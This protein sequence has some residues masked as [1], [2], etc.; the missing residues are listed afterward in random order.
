MTDFDVIVP[1]KEI[2][3]ER[4]EECRQIMIKGN[5]AYRKWMPTI[6]RRRS[7]FCRDLIVKGKLDQVLPFI[8]ADRH[9]EFLSDIPA[10]MCVES[11]IA[12]LLGHHVKMVVN[13]ASKWAKNNNG[14]KSTKR[15]YYD[16]G[17]LASEGFIA[18]FD[19]IR[20]YN[21]NDIVFMTYAWMTVSRRMFAS[22][23][24]TSPMS[25]FTR[26]ERQ[27]L[28]KIAKKQSQSGNRNIAEAVANEI[29][30]DD[31]AALVR[32]MLTIKVVLASRLEESMGRMED[33]NFDYTS[34][35]AGASC[36]RTS[37]P[38]DAWELYDFIERANLD[39]CEQD[40]LLSSLTP[41]R[42]WQ[43]EC[44]VRHGV[45]KTTVQNTLQRAC[46]KIRRVAGLCDTDT[47]VAQL[48]VASMAG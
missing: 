39:E 28:G 33:G 32:E 23:M 31:E 13:L 29:V 4:M 48:M 18:M 1:H 14:E 6:T 34:F 7:R 10:I 16:G 25:C 21:R 41:F 30:N 20:N 12:D 43:A 44:S 2:S 37:Q 3:G 46:N 42:G 8:P 27:L 15:S 17:D 22:L 9:A 45:S 26:Q 35:R 24:A 11:V 36:D 38:S 5:N 40:V 47:N 19:A